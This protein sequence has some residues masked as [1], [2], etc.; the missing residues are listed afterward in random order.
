MQNSSLTVLEISQSLGTY[1]ANPRQDTIHG[2]HPNSFQ[3][4]WDDAKHNFVTWL[5]T[6]SGIYWIFGKPASGKSTLMKFL[7]RHDRTREYLDSQ[8][9]KYSMC[10]YFFHEL[11]ELDTQQE[12]SITGLLHAIL[13]QLLQLF[14]E[15]IRT[16]RPLY[17]KKVHPHKTLGNLTSIWTIENLKEAL[18]KLATQSFVSQKVCLFIDGFDE[19]REERGNYLDFLKSWLQKMTGNGLSVKICLSSRDIPAMRERLDTHQ[20][21]ELHIFTRKD[22]TN[23]VSEELIKTKSKSISLDSHGHEVITRNLIKKVVDKAQGVF[24][25]VKLVVA[26]LVSGLEAAEDEEDLEVRLQSLPQEL[27]DLYAHIISRIPCKDLHTPFKYF[28][29]LLRAP[30]KTCTL[31]LL[32]FL[33]AVQNPK[34]CLQNLDESGLIETSP[35]EILEKLSSLKDHL[36]ER[37]GNLIQV[38]SR[39]HAPRRWEPTRREN[40]TFIHL[41]F[42]EYISR[43]SVQQGIKDRIKTWRMPIVPT[44]D[45]LLMASCLLLLKTQKCYIPHWIDAKYTNYH[46]IQHEKDVPRSPTSEISGRLQTPTL[47]GAVENED[48][49]EEYT[50]EICRRAPDNLIAKFFNYAGNLEQ[51]FHNAE[52]GSCYIDELDRF[53]TKADQQWASKFYT[54][55]TLHGIPQPDVLCLAVCWKLKYYVKKKIKEPQQRKKRQLPLLFYAMNPPGWAH[56]EVDLDLLEI[57]LK[58]GAKPNESYNYNGIK[59]TTWEHTLEHFLR[60]GS[61]HPL[62]EWR[63]VIELM[64]SYGAN[65]NQKIYARDRRRYTTVL[66]L[67]V[68]QYGKVDYDGEN[69]AR[70]AFLMLLDRGAEGE[71]KNSD[72]I[73]AFEY[74]IN[75]CPVIANAFCTSESSL[76]NNE[77]SPGITECSS[78]HTPKAPQRNLRKTA[79][80]DSK[81]FKRRHSTVEDERSEALASR[82]HEHRPPREESNETPKYRVSLPTTESKRLKKDR[83]GGR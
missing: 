27:G 29:L 24:V 47:D 58:A 8:G 54:R 75:E 3:W 12:S 33:M 65:P 23:F 73:S 61:A 76:V 34:K 22:I 60:I 69:E 37:C 25:W 4:L 26:D 55:R 78:V 41:S 9:G 70:N 52:I 42:K 72:H 13:F 62:Q 18:M 44:A 2:A 67:L 53:F 14:P 16:I 28:Q 64:L 77:G 39:R 11:S 6:G 36:R 66:H 21:L 63:K 80:P 20:S 1:A 5:K 56:E 10:Q 38:Q 45:L 30:G 15:L 74:A 81:Y 49:E 19:C 71:I 57:L 50:E 59:K 68:D 46:H 31:T 82:Q 83:K 35:E 17:T 7:L 51:F 40:V 32:Q 48:D 79:E 43:D